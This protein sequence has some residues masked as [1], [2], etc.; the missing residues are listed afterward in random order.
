MSKK[1]QGRSRNTR[2]STAR[3]TI[4]VQGARVQNLKN[5]SLE[6]P[7]DQLMVV[8]ETNGICRIFGPLQF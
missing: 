2:P 6:I 3:T 1:N 4:A 8:T 7:R 5:I